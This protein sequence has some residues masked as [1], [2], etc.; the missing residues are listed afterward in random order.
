[1]A[2]LTVCRDQLLKWVKSKASDGSWYVGLVMNGSRYGTRWARSARG[3]C[4]KK[5]PSVSIS[6]LGESGTLET[7]DQNLEGQV[8]SVED[9]EGPTCEPT[10]TFFKRKGKHN[11]FYQRAKDGAIGSFVDPRDRDG[12]LEIVKLSHAN[13]HGIFETSSQKEEN[14]RE[15]CQEVSISTLPK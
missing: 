9:P 5:L 14:G 4:S 1:M 11:I 2:P 6:R 8:T 15:Y 7:H 13:A 10:E 3:D 12:Q